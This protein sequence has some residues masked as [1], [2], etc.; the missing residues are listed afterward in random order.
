MHVSNGTPVRVVVLQ[1]LLILDGLSHR[2]RKGGKKKTVPFSP[3]N[4][5]YRPRTWSK[6]DRHSLI[7][8]RSHSPPRN[9]FTFRAQRVA[10]LD[11][12]DSRSLVTRLNHVFDNFDETARRLDP[13]FVRVLYARTHV[14]VYIPGFTPIKA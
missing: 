12:A 6:Y 4:A 7:S 5:F 10:T 9:E 3:S 11:V 2:H 8:N 13:A 14:H 1:S